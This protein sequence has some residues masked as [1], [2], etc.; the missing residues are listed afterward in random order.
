[1]KFGFVQEHRETFRVGM[2]CRILKV[3]RSGYYAW[4]A[5]QPSPR[6][7]ENRALVERIPAIRR[8]SRE[9]YGAPRGYG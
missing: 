5:R 1:V 4:R 2:M 9:T 8:S 7:P 6:D 3:S